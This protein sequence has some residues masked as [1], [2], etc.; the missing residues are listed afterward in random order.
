MIH[1]LKFNVKIKYKDI[2]MLKK[3]TILTMLFTLNLNATPFDAVNSSAVS[4]LASK[5]NIESNAKILGLSQAAYQH[6]V[7]QLIRLEFGTVDTGLKKLPELIDFKKLDKYSDSELTNIMKQQR[8]TLANY[9]SIPVE[10]LQTFYTL[11]P[12]NLL[13]N[14]GQGDN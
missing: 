13:Q 12:E 11:V 14:N 6:A 1:P 7:E 3:I 5:F 9:L 4:Q 8:T 2:N 10:K